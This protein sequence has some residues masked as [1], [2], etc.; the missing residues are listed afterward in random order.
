VTVELF[1]GTDPE[2]RAW[3]PDYVH[4]AEA[5]LRVAGKVWRALHASRELYLLAF[6]LHKPNADLL[7]ISERGIGVAEMK[8]HRGKIT[9]GEEEEWLAGGRPMVGH[10]ATPGKDRP[11][12]SYRNP[13]AQVQGHGARLFEQ[14]IPLIKPLYPALSRGKRRALRLQTTVCFTN[15]DADI[16]ELLLRL[17]EWCA[18]RLQSWESDFAITTPEELPAW[19]SALRFEVKSLDVPPYYPFR[20]NPAD[21]ESM[22][23]SLHPVERWS[24]A[25]RMLPAVR[26]GSLVAMRGEHALATHMLWEEEARIGR[27]SVRCTIVVPAGCTRVSRQ[28]MTVRRVGDKVLLHDMGSNNGTYVDGERVEGELPLA[29]G[30]R[31]MLG[32]QSDSAKECTYVFRRLD[33]ADDACVSTEDATRPSGE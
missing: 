8:S 17:P 28:H 4:E 11:A 16:S 14:C 2:D 15:P 23:R 26:Y 27:D 33:Q 20:L 1:V 6:N 29:D 5:A 7:V 18:G 21:M 9:L 30:A 12:S 24:A 22:L 19:V 3:E 13:H 25:E 10:H 31:I 32:G